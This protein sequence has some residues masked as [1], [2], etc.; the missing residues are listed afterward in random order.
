MGFL[1]VRQMSMAVKKIRSG[2][3]ITEEDV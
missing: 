2:T 3:S 1:E